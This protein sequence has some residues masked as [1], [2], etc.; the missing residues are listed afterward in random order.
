MSS[1]SWPQVGTVVRLH[2][3]IRVRTDIETHADIDTCAE[4]DLVSYEFVQ[5]YHFDQAKYNAPLLEVVGRQGAPTYGVWTI[6]ITVYDSRG[7]KREFSRPCVAVDRD[8]RLSGSP[9]LLSN[10]T[11][12]EMRIVLAPWRKQWWFEYKKETMEWLEP[13]QFAKACRNQARVFAVVKTPEEVWL[14]PEEEEE[15][16]ASRDR[17]PPEL[18]AFRDVFEAQNSRI[19]PPRKETDHSIELKEDASPPYGPIYPLSQAELAE[20]RKYL[21]E[22]L[23][24]GRIKPSKSPAGAPILFV[25]KKDGGLRLCVD[26]RGLNKVSVKNRYPLPLISEILDR[27]SGAQYLSK[28]DVQDAYY[29]IRIR[30]GEEWKTAFRTRYGHFEY[31]VMPFGLTNAPAT[32]QSYIYTALYG[33]LDVICIA[34]L[35]DIL[36]FSKTYEEHTEYLRL[37]LERLRKAQLFVKASK[38]RFYKEQVEFLGFIVGRNG[39]AMDP[40]RVRAIQE[41]EQPA[42]YRDI[43]VFLGFCNF[44]RRFIEKYSL[45]ALPLTELLKGTKD[46]KKPGN[47]ELN[48]R[49]SKAF[50]DL[51]YAFSTAPLLCYF[52][53]ERPI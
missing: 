35:D 32:F 21:D 44:Y 33:L 26:Y 46:G 30:E 6:P 50:R 40:E 16:T 11:I 1:D 43:Q 3:P 23:A 37:V 15:L 38:C 47:V 13:H 31:M 36:I 5:K 8:P 34:Y 29:R 51:L 4:V 41:W 53:P 10:T 28:I 14:P 25:P 17:V 2:V 9:V 49:E 20:L 39:I 45:I 19:M 18:T 24:N 22:N 52:D 27:L 42:S 7:T 48:D 12:Q